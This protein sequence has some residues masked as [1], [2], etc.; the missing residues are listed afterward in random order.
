MECLVK[1]FNIGEDDKIAIK[2]INKLL[3]ENDSEEPLYS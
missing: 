3:I 2:E 1:T